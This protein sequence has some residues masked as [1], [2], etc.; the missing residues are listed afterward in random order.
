MNNHKIRQPV[1][2]FLLFALIT[3]HTASAAGPPC[4][5]CAGVRVDDPSSIAA[6]LSS[7]PKIEG[8]ARLYVAWPAELDGSADAAG[9]ETVRELGGTP[10]MTVT[11][12]TPRPVREHGDELAKELEDLARLARGSGERAHFQLQWEPSQGGFEI[13]DF[14]FLLKRAAVAVTGARG[15]ARVLAGPLP[16]DAELL[17]ALYGEEVAAYLDGVVFA[18]GDGLAESLAVLA[19]LDPGKP[20]ALD[21]LDWPAEDAHTLSLAAEYTEVGVG[22]TFFALDRPDEADLT[23]LK[24]LA[25]EFQGDLSLDPTTK[26]QG[27]D[28]AWTFVRGEDLGLRVIAEATPGERLAL[29]FEDPQLKSPAAI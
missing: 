3:S 17:R 15:D 14:A 19:E 13:T 25:R 6:A 5:P 16:A 2:L 21:A 29:L 11:F 10:W 7:D 4:R 8:E 12:R 23:P 22:V 20:A 26:P 1:Y 9:F 27:S 28:R 18:P 24:L